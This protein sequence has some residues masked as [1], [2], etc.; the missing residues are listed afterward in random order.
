VK[1]LPS[2]LGYAA[3]GFSCAVLLGGGFLAGLAGA[4]LGMAAVAIAET[5]P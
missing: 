2:A 3:F 1:Y 4:A 5:K